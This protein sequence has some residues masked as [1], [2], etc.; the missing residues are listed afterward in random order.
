MRRETSVCVLNIFVL[1]TPY[2]D[3]IVKDLFD[4]FFCVSPTSMLYFLNTSRCKQV[5]A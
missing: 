1:C 2:T 3:L 4:P 5:Y